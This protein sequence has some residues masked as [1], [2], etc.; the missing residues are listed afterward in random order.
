VL[1]DD[2]LDLRRVFR[3][4]A[5]GLDNIFGDLSVQ[6]LEL[7]G[8]LFIPDLFPRH[9]PICTGCGFLP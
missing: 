5:E 1:I 4:D 2:Q 8:G 7:C 6:V 3:G 9:L